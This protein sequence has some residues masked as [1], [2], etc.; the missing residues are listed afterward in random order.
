MVLSPAVMEYDRCDQPYGYHAPLGPTIRAYAEIN[1]L[2]YIKF[3]LNNRQPILTA[4][5]SAV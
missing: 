2:G 5:P 4:S 1:L 3:Q